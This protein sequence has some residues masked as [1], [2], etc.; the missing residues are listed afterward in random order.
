VETRTLE[1]G[2]RTRIEA[3]EGFVKMLGL[4]LARSYDESQL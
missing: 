4:L 3:D 1:N 2:V